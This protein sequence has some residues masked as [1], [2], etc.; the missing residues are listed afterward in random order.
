MPGFYQVFQTAP[1]R[2]LTTCHYN[3]EVRPLCYALAHRY[4][5]TLWH[6]FAAFARSN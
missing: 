5:V 2:N 6:Y 4:A 1:G 3:A